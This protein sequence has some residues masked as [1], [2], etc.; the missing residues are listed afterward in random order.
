MVAYDV[1]GT[2]SRR[3]PMARAGHVRKKKAAAG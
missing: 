3:K 2:H 1:G